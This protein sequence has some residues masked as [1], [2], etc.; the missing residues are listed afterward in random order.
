MEFKFECPHCGQR[1]AAD[2]AEAGN[3]G[4]CPTCMKPITI[5]LIALAPDQAVKA[6]MEESELTVQSIPRVS[7]WKTVWL[8]LV[9]LCIGLALLGLATYLIGYNEAKPWQQWRFDWCLHLDPNLGDNIGVIAVRWIKIVAVA[10]FGIY[11]TGWALMELYDVF[12]HSTGRVKK[13]T[14]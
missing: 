11:C 5:P 14:K 12:R 7:M 10:G 2:E 3:S 1:I 9:M 13:R 4:A 6:L 8:P